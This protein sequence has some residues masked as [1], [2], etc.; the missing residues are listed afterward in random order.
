MVKLK[1][2]KEETK[3]PNQK[4]VEVETQ[5]VKESKKCSVC[6]RDITTVVIEILQQLSQKEE[7]VRTSQNQTA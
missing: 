6:D 3:I 5:E 2:V 7:S 4:Y 1:H